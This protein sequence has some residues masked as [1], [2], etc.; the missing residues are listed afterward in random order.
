[1]RSIMFFPNTGRFEMERG[2]TILIDG[3][4]WETS[5]LQE[6]GLT[7]EVLPGESDHSTNADDEVK[8]N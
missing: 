4:D 1:M 8:G 6:L 7:N 2:K 5:D 3:V